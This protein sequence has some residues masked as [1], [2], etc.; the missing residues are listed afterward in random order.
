MRDDYLGFDYG[1]EKDSLSGGPASS[2]NMNDLASLL[3]SITGVMD[4][5][6]GEDEKRKSV[7][8]TGLPQ[9]EEGSQ[10][11]NFYLP[12]EE[13]SSQRPSMSAGKLG[14]LGS[15]AQAGAKLYKSFD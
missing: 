14:S 8:I 5:L 15:L 9:G 4:T 6:K 12:Q 11:L 13:S 2:G 7:E 10:S 1:F 3:M